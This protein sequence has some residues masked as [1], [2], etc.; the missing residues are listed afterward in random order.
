MQEDE[1]SPEG[2]VIKLDGSLGTGDHVLL[3]IITTDK[4]MGEKRETFLLPFALLNFDTLEKFVVL[5]LING[6][7]VVRKPKVKE[8]EEVQ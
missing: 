8:G 1:Q 3:T 2:Q 7:E 4:V 5:N 6:Y